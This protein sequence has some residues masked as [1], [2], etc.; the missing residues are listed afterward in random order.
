MD[1]LLTCPLD[2][3]ANI[4]SIPVYTYTVAEYDSERPWVV[5]GPLRQM[6]VELD[7]SEDFLAW[8]ARAWPRPRYQAVLV[9]GLPPW[10]STR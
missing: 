8:A 6:T 3:S 4:R 7:D 9:P 2:L 1:A 10:E 5:V